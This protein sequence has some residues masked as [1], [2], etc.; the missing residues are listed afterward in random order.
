MANEKKK[1]N[2]PV[3]QPAS[4]DV[5][6]AP[7]GAAPP[8]VAASELCTHDNPANLCD[9]CSKRCGR[10]GCDHQLGDHAVSAPHICLEC[11]CLGFV[12]VYHE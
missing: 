3:L 1:S 11:P 6:P 5:K 8:P 10:V 2:G 4:L 7:Q 9:T 12:E